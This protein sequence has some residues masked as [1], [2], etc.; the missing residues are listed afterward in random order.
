MSRGDGYRY[1]L[2]VAEM[3]KWLRFR[4]GTPDFD[5]KKKAGAAFDK[6]PI[7]TMKGIVAFDIQWADATG[8]L[9]LWDTIQFSAEYKATASYWTAATRISLWQAKE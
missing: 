4:I 6:T 2:R 5:E 9:D 8:H 1:A 3:R 7:A